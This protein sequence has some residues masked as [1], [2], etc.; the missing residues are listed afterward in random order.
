MSKT[1][2]SSIYCDTYEQTA[3]DKAVFKA[4]NSLGVLDK[5]KPGSKILIKPNLLSDHRPDEAITTHPAIIKSIVQ[6]VKSKGA[7]P[8]IGDSPGNILKGIENVW[9]KTEMTSIAAEAGIRL[10]SFETSG[11]KEMPVKHPTVKSISVAKTVF[12][13]DAIINVPKLKTHTFMGLTC[14]VKNF[15]GCVPGIRKIEYH[16]MAP[17]PYDFGLLLGEL[18]GILKDKILFTVV[19]GIE[20]LEG[21]GP[22]TK[23]IKRKYNI[24]CAAA[25]AVALDTYIT[26]CIEKNYKKNF[27]IKILKNYGDTDYEKFEFKGDG[28]ANF[29]FEAVKLPITKILNMIPVSLA[30]FAGNYI[31]RFLWIKP[32]IEEDKCVK[33][34]QCLKSCPAKTIIKTDKGIIYINEEN[35][36]S[37]FCCHELCGYKAIEIKESIIAKLFIRLKKNNK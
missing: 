26:Q 1:I 2:I 12:D 14:G 7:V 32:F 3:V 33:C 10:V 15:Y 8:F 4:I 24:V 17:S 9:E 35:C 21:N 6:I 5:I 22:S 25:D 28:V 20:G 13:F 30:R 37:C 23:G 36:I 19:D 27:F 18:Y 16:K 29:N 34:G 11:V 31:G